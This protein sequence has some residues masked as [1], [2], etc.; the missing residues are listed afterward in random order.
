MCFA[1]SPSWYAIA[2]HAR[3]AVSSFGVGEIE[4]RHTTDIYGDSAR[5][6]CS[7]HGWV[8]LYALGLRPTKRERMARAHGACET[9]S[10][11]CEGHRGGPDD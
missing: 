1:R 11:V 2:R 7:P 3:A 8:T 6:P 4:G 5:C 9:G 10:A